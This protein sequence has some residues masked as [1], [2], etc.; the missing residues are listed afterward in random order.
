M[1][2]KCNDTFAKELDILTILGKIRDSYSMLKYF[3]GKQHDK[4]LQ[5]NADRTVELSASDG[6]NSDKE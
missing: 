3:K 4:L 5:F 2:D 6:S 1:L